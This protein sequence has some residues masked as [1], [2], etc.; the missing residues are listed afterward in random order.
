MKIV[1]IKIMIM[2]MSRKKILLVVKR[3][4]TLIT[5]IKMT[6]AMTPM[7]IIIMMR[8]IRIIRMGMKRL[9]KMSDDACR[10]DTC[11]SSHCHMVMVGVRVGRGLVC[12]VKK[13]LGFGVWGLGF[14]LRGRVAL[15][16]PVSGR[17]FEQS[18]E[19]RVCCEQKLWL[20]PPRSLGMMFRVSDLGV[21][22]GFRVLG[23]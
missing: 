8:I 2:I 7:L 5:K 19:F 14:R 21:F 6:A 15:F 4:I 17:G 1:M 18:S 23:F 12:R 13:G 20:R 3:R 9:I 10:N 22:Q 16:S 11:E